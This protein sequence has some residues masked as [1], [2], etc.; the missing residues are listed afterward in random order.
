MLLPQLV[1]H[2]EWGSILGSPRRGFWLNNATKVGLSRGTN[3]W[4]PPKKLFKVTHARIA[5]E[6]SVKHLFKPSVRLFRQVV[7]RGE[8]ILQLQL[9]GVCKWIVRYVNVV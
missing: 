2:G 6:V 3:A 1:H 8:G 7:N 9:C 5:I 4:F